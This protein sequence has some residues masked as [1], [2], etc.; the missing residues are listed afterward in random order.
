MNQASNFL[1]GSFCN[2]DN[3]R[4]T[5]QIRKETSPSILQ[6][7]FSSRTNTYIFTPIPTLLLDQ[8]SKTNW[9]FLALKSTRTK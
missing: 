2:W 1:G 5:V 7:D 4:A 9:V 3:G 8:S 6:D